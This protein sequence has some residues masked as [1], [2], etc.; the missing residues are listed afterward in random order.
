MC[1]YIENMTDIEIV[2][3][4]DPSGKYTFDWVMEQVNECRKDNQRN[5]R[6][7]NTGVFNCLDIVYSQSDYPKGTNPTQKY[8]KEYLNNLK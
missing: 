4:L 7:I 3:K 6:S 5:Q 8:S 2:K 1:I